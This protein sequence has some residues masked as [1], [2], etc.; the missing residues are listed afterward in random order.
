MNLSTYSDSPRRL[1]RNTCEC[2]NE[3]SNNA[4]ACDRCTYLDGTR[5]SS[6]IIEAL[7]TATGLSIAEICGVLGTPYD[8]HNGGAARSI[9]RTVVSLMKSGRVR[10]Y[11]RDAESKQ[12]EGRAFGSRGLV[13]VG[14]WGCWAYTLTERGAQ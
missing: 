3:K 2:G 9:H 8:W 1:P 5:G 6:R 10:R 14:G 11:W 13:T 4:E 12:V 7:R